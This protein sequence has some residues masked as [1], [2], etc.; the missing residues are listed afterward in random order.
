MITPYLNPTVN[1]S[2]NMYENEYAVYLISYWQDFGAGSWC[3]GQ[4]RVFRSDPGILMGSGCSD[5]IRVFWSD[6][7]FKMWSDL[8]PGKTTRIWN[9]AYWATWYNYSP[10]SWEG[11]AYG[12]AGPPPCPRSHIAPLNF[13]SPIT[14]RSVVTKHQWYGIS[15]L[16]CKTRL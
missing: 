13:S 2:Q 1:N 12:S 16:R 11:W 5:G 14:Q 7:V 9:P 10:C 4:M 15:V 3:S 8:D 6:P